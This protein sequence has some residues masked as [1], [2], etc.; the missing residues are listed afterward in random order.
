MLVQLTGIDDLV[1]SLVRPTTAA[2]F[3][4]ATYTHTL[5]WKTCLVSVDLVWRNCECVI[6]PEVTLCG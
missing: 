5:T 3:A 1:N 4:V 2:E 6:R